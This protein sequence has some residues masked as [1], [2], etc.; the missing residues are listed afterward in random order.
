MQA[1]LQGDLHMRTIFA[2]EANVLRNSPVRRTKF[3]TRIGMNKIIVKARIKAHAQAIG[4]MDKCKTV[5]FLRFF[6]INGRTTAH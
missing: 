1:F 5:E 6:E 4:K 2:R 3:A